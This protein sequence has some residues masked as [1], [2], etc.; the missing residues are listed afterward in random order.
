MIQ[1]N[2]LLKACVIIILLFMNPALSSDDRVVVNMMVDLDL[3]PAKYLNVS[4]DSNLTIPAA[5][6]SEQ[7]IDLECNSRAKI[8]NEVELKGLNV[9]IY[10]TGDYL[11]E[12]V[13]N[14]SYGLS[15]AYLS[16]QPNYE[17][18]LHGMTTDEKLENMSYGEQDLRIAESK[19]NVEEA[20]ICNG[21]ERKVV[22][23]FRPQSFSQN[24]DTLLILDNPLSFSVFWILNPCFP[25]NFPDKSN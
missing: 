9:T 15:V 16:T 24:N 23:G 2:R 19:M 21:K 20:H 6:P 10:L 4:S 5:S 12:R 7:K 14:Y 25:A 13:E 11:K 22:K 18:A 17:L 3:C 8:L 1:E